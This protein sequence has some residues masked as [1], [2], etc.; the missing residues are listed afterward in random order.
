MSPIKDANTI[1]TASPTGFTPLSIGPASPNGTF[2]VPTESILAEAQKVVHGDRQDVYGHPYEDFSYIARMWSAY[3]EKKYRMG[4]SL[5]SQDVPNMMIMVK[6]ARLA[7]SPDHRDSK[8]DIAGYAECAG[9]VDER[10]KNTYT[11]DKSL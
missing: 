7:N 1:T 2:L 4:F 6:L 11:P 3:I 9:T 8:I 5:S 10:L